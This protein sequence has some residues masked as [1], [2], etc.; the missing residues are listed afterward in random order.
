VPI[1]AVFPVRSYVLS[2]ALLPSLDICHDRLTKMPPSGELP[3]TT[4]SYTQGYKSRELPGTTYSYTQGYKSRELV[5]QARRNQHFRQIRLSLINQGAA[6]AVRYDR[7]SPR[8]APQSD[9]PCHC[10]QPF[11]GR[12]VAPRTVAGRSSARQTRDRCRGRSRDACD[13]RRLDRVGPAVV[14]QVKPGVGAD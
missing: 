7:N 9:F 8:K 5:V 12:K 3:G 10:G 6:F 11:G 2:V 1:R 4:Y 13:G 14:R